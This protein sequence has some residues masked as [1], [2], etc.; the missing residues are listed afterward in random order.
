MI[1]PIGNSPVATPS[2]VARRARPVGIPNSTV[3]TRSAIPSEI[4]AAICALTLPL[5]I[6]PRSATT[7]TAAAS[8]DSHAF[9]N[10]S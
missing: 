10:G 9:P 5:A 8:V 7:G 6:S 4:T 1:Q 2:A 3:A